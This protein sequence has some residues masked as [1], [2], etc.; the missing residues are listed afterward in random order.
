MTRAFTID[1]SFGQQTG[2]RTK[3]SLE[4]CSTQQTLDP[5]GTAAGVSEI[6]PAQ[7]ET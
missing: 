3:P 4:H 2:D 6:A 7:M 1:H 5:A